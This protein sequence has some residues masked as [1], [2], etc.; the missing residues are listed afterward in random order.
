MLHGSISLYGAEALTLQVRD[1]RKIQSA[2]MW[3]WGRMIRV[4][5]TEHHTDESIQPR[6]GGSVG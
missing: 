3:F 6:I 4:S 1:E 2:E 5:W